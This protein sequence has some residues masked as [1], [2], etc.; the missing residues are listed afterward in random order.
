MDIVFLFVLLFGLLCFGVPVAIALAGSSA[1]FICPQRHRRRRWS[2][3]T[4]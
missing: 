4:G 2:W 1:I 3:R